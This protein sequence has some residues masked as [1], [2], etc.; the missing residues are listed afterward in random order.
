MTS[1]F[2]A[3]LWLFAAVPGVPIRHLAEEDGEGIGKQRILE[4]SEVETLASSAGCQEYVEV[5]KLARWS[6]FT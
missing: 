3:S 4:A 6:D 2:K 1:Y 5:R